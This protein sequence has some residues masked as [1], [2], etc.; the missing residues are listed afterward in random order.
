MKKITCFLLGFVVFLMSFSGCSRDNDSISYESIGEPPVPMKM[1][2]Q[3]MNPPN[4]HILEFSL[5]EDWV[6]GTTY[7][8]I[9]AISASAQN[10][11]LNELENGEKTAVDENWEAN[12][13]YKLEQFP[14]YIHIVYVAPSEDIP[15]FD[16][17]WEQEKSAFEKRRIEFLIQSLKFQEKLDENSLSSAWN[18]LETMSGLPSATSEEI[19]NFP[20]QFQ[21]KHY[22]G[23]QG[24]ILE[25]KNI[26]EWKN[27]KYIIVEY[28]KEDI[29]YS[30]WGAF[31]SSMDL[32]SGN[33]ALWIMDS[34]TIS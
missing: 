15:F 18:P 32:P 13:S 34:F 16:I 24:K 12:I 10:A 1:V 17:N 11:L 14:L 31:D 25:I 33:I 7:F 27:K 8:G 22:I 20:I 28:H 2:R 9:S 23:K 26:L 29:P 4:T 19:Q 21:Y 6:Y 5:P 30:V 3:Q